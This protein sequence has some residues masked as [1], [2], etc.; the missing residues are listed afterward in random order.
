M[1]THFLEKPDIYFSLLKKALCS[2]CLHISQ[3]SPQEYKSPSWS[4]TFVTHHVLVLIYSQPEL[5]LNLQQI[6][7]WLKPLPRTDEQALDKLLDLHT[8]FINQTNI[9][10]LQV[11]S[12][13]EFCCL[14]NLRD[15]LPPLLVTSDLITLFGQVSVLVEGNRL[16]IKML[17]LDL[18]MYFL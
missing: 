4:G 12:F 11:L 2:S 10:F 7:E 6:Q 16:S 14:K 17:M 5:N 18:C 8:G 1:N 13:F 9:T 15:V 3:M